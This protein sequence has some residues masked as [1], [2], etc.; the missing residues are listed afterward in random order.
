MRRLRT[1]TRVI[2]SMGTLER[3]DN[4]LCFKGEGKKVYIPVENTKEIYAL[5]EINLNSKLFGLLAKH[6]IILH[7]F[8][9]YCN[10]CGSFYPR[11]KHISGKLT[12]EQVGCYHKYK[13]KIAK[14]IVSGIGKNIYEVLYHYYRH[15]K[16]EL[17]EYL[18]WLA[19]KVDERLEECVTINDIMAV[20]GEIWSKFYNSFQYFLNPDFIMNKRVKRPPDN[21]INALISFGNSVLYTKTISQLYQTQLDPSISFLHSP[22]ERRLSLSLDLS[23]VFKPI[24]VFK[25]IF[26]CI[27]NRRLSVEKHFRKKYNYC[28]LND[29]GK[30]IFL[31]ELFLRMEETFLNPKL[32]KTMSYLTA[33]KYD[34]Y[35]LIKFILEGEEFYPFNIKEKI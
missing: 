3:K 6:G 33:I 11:E 27:N 8:D 10:Y 18:D 30:Q 23:E 19:L 35:K 34:G 4:S 20:E 24:I 7:I 13:E 22:A 16:Q 25:T 15:G 31:T 5:Q 14:R 1:S 32:N 12:I 28:L 21:P 26:E 17:K 2:M 29:D 9:Y